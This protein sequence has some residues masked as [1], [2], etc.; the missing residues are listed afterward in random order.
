MYSVWKVPPFSVRVTRFAGENWNVMDVTVEIS[1]NDPAA[2]VELPSESGDGHISS[3]DSTPKCTVA[4]DSGFDAYSGS[5]PLKTQVPP[6]R[7]SGYGVNDEAEQTFFPPSL[8]AVVHL[9]VHS[10]GLSHSAWP[11]TRSSVI[12][13]VS[14]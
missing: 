10:S 13:S 4:T 2:S 7:I 12:N 9:V 6:G 8:L 11:R 5:P 1:I 14:Q 3:F